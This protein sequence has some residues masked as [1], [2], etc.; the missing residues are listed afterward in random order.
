M[1][2]SDFFFFCQSTATE[3]ILRYQAYSLHSAI[4]YKTLPA[5]PP[6]CFSLLLQIKE[7]RSIDS[8]HVGRQALIWLQFFD[9]TC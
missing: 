1:F 6:M 4:S 3:L 8:E 2:L 7:P 5:L 9:V